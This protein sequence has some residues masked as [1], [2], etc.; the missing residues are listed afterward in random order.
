MVRL[1]KE[2]ERHGNDPELFAGLVHACRYCGLFEE[3]IAA[4]EEARRL[5]P[6]IPTSYEQT[7]LMTCDFDR[8]LGIEK[9]ATAAGGDEVIRVIGLGLAG[10]REEA[11]EALL[12]LYERVSVTAFRTWARTLF[13]WLDR[14]PDQMQESR[15]TL[16]PL[17]IMDD[18][19]A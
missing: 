12:P 5:D 18:P 17:G 19:E 10:R 4:H 13:A 9:P 6:N 16:G 2:A 8:L 7:V 15:A 14:R 3:G 11:R 1:L